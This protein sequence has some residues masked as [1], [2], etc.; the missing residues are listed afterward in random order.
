FAF[1]L[2]FSTMKGTD[3]VANGLTDQNPQNLVTANP[4]FPELSGANNP[5][6]D[7]WSRYGDDRQAR[8]AIAIQYKGKTETF[9]VA[10]TGYLEKELT[11]PTVK[12]IKFDAG[13]FYKFKKYELSY[14]Y[15]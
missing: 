12:N 2:N 14:S 15:R 4:R 10:R 5:A 9:N 11:Y 6:T 13:L 7:Q 3:W 8:Q 1:K